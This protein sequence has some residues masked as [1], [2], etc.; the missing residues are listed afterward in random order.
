MDSDDELFA[1]LQSADFTEIVDDRELARRSHTNSRRIGQLNRRD[2]WQERRQGW[3]ALIGGFVVLFGGAGAASAGLLHGQPDQQDLVWCYRYVPQD[4]TDD[5]A[6]SGVLFIDSGQTTARKAVDLCYG[7]TDGTIAA[8]PNPVSQCVLPD[9]DV[10][11]LP[12]AHCADVG[13]P[14]SDVRQ[15]PTE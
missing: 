11:V 1:A 13:L 10:G 6:R 2:R 4:L 14:E 9:G 3:L 5:A 7:N 15:R 8:I 12:I